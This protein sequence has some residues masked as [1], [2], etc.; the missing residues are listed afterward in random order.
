MI[1]KINEMNKIKE[2]FIKRSKRKFNAADARSLSK[3]GK[4]YEDIEIYQIILEE[5]LRDIENR[6]RVK[7]FCLTLEITLELEDNLEGLIEEL[8]SRGFG[9]AII[10][11]NIVEE[12]NS[13]KFL[14]ITWKK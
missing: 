1:N 6:A 7:K 8:K 11:N 10:D 4:I 14:I 3:Y 2:F 12:L 13:S 5:T 9:A